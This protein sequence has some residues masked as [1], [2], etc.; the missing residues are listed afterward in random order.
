MKAPII[1]KQ[2]M[3]VR[4]QLRKTPHPAIWIP[5]TRLQGSKPAR[6]VILFHWLFIGIERVKLSSGPDEVSI[7][8][9]WGLKPLRYER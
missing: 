4:Y 7:V 1:R 6:G 9:N 5:A 2:K 8:W 3:V